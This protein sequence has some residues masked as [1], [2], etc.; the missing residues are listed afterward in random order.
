MRLGAGLSSAELAA[1]FEEERRWQEQQSSGPSCAGGAPIGMREL[2]SLVDRSEAYEVARAALARFTSRARA[3]VLLDAPRPDSLELAPARRLIDW[4]YERWCRTDRHVLEAALN[5]RV[6]HHSD[7][8]ASSRSLR[9]AALR[10]L[11]PPA[12]RRRRLR[13]VAHYPEFRRLQDEAPELW[14]EACEVSPELE[15]W[16]TERLEAEL[17]R[18]SAELARPPADPG[19]K[20][21]RREEQRAWAERRL[22]AVRGRR[23][24]KLL[25]HRVVTRVLAAP[26]LA[27]LEA[28]LGAELHPGYRRRL[29]LGL[30]EH[31]RGRARA[32]LHSGL[33][34]P[35][36]GI[37]V[38]AQVAEA[39][40]RPEVFARAL[41]HPEPACRYL[42]IAG[43]EALGALPGAA[44]DALAGDQ[45][46]FVR[47][48][49]LAC[50]AGR[51]E[52]RGEQALLEHAAG[53]EQSVRVRAEATRWLAREPARHV[54]LLERALLEDHASEDDYHLPV[55]EEAAFGLARA[56]GERALTALVR[57]ALVAPSN[58]LS[59]AL[60][61]YLG[62]LRAG[63]GAP[64]EIWP[65]LW[66]RR[67]PYP[68]WSCE[69]L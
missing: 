6:A 21:E 26:D 18:I 13:S 7:E 28:V 53:A 44:L 45:D 14:R 2:L 58:P 68:G 40:E 20:P 22:D 41:E 8:R 5:D 56:G 55:A 29:E 63:P 49:A 4:L 9:V 34:R 51:G 25:G 42:G 52:A 54:D 24:L 3:E 50:Q 36:Q 39:P 35:G 48:R 61:S 33:D 23:E 31:D 32:W 46:V 62:A 10:E 47:L 64:L 12:E 30:W 59:D 11:E 69:V 27:R 1:L 37:W 38:L 67:L 66:R 65:N 16:P 57:A 43:L 15:P 60:R 19:P 17:A